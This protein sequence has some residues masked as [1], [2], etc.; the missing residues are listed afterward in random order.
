MKHTHPRASASE[1]FRPSMLDSYVAAALISNGY[2]E[3]RN[4]LPEF[5]SDLRR[6][7]KYGFLIFLC[8]ESCV[9]IDTSIV[10]NISVWRIPQIICRIW[11]PSSNDCAKKDDR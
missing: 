8:G 9:H 11:N 7:V 3:K 4:T 10:P 2:K 6:A 5:S 1:Y